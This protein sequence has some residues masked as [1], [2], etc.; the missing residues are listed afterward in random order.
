MRI[1][2][3]FKVVPGILDSLWQEM[4]LAIKGWRCRAAPPGEDLKCPRDGA[5]PL[6]T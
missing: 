6:I 2:I 5:T 3:R 1:Y 4:Q